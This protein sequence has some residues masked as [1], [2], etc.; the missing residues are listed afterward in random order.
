MYLDYNHYVESNS[1]TKDKWVRNVIKFAIFDSQKASEK[2][3]L[4]ASEQMSC[5]Q[6]SHFLLE[7]T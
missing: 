4:S 3:Q 1:K 7:F 6:T 5:S 2:Q